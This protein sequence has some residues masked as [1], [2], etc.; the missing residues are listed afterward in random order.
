M[1][2]MELQNMYY[3]KFNIHLLKGLKWNNKLQAQKVVNLNIL[4]ECKTGK[5]LE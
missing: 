5:D 4:K 3:Y 1:I 2:V